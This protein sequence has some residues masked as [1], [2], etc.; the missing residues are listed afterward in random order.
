MAGTVSSIVVACLL[1]VKKL[2]SPQEHFVQLEIILKRHV[3]PL[4]AVDC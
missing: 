4:E 3:A 2:R 1:D